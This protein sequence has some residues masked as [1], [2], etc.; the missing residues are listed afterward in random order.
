MDELSLTDSMLDFH[1]RNA[2]EAAIQVVM[3]LGRFIKYQV[4][5]M[6]CCSSC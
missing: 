5:R 1:V 3:R 6:N 2:L 4:I